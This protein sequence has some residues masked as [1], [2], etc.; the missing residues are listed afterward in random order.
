MGKVWS[1]KEWE[2]KRLTD[3]INKKE[4][5]IKSIE[6]NPFHPNK[7]T[8]PALLQRVELLKLVREEKFNVSYD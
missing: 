7:A 5:K 4:R 1:N 6:G 8:L 2:L 3:S